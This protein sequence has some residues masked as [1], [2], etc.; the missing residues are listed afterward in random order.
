MFSFGV[1]RPIDPKIGFY[2]VS[3]VSF[4]YSKNETDPATGLKK[5]LKEKRNLEIAECSNKYFLYEDQ[6]QI[7]GYSIDK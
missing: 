5:R 7:K 3:E 6:E 2:S 1:G 4:H